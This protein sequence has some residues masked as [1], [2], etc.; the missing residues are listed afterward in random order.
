MLAAGKLRHRITLQT[1]Q[2]SQDSNG[3]WQ[4]DN[5]EP[6]IEWETLGTV[7]AAILPLTA[8]ELIAAQ[9]EH[10]KVTG[11]IV[12]RYRGDGYYAMRAYHAAKG[13]YYNIEGIIADSDS[14]IEFLTLAVSEGMRYQDQPAPPPPVHAFLYKDDGSAYLFKDDGTSQLY[15]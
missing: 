10:S 1:P 11:K 7:W 13:Q 15:K 2:P 8:R 9:S 5:G 3:N 6:L 12:I 4:A 14:G